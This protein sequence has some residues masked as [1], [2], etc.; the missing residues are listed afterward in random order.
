MSDIS[1]KEK[2]EL[3]K[4]RRE[5]A[6]QAQKYHKEQKK[7]AKKSSDATQVVR[8]PKVK[9][10]SGSKIEEA[11]NSGKTTKF[12][13]ISREEKFRRESEERIRNLEPQD[14]EDGYY[15]DEYSEKQRSER[16]AQVIRKQEHEVI[17]RNK[18]PVTQKQA[19]NRRILIGVAILIAVLVIGAILSL[20]VLFKTEKI[21]IDG[22]EYYYEDQIIAFSNVSLQQNIFLAAMG[23]TPKEIV[24]NL[25]YVEDA[26]ISFAIPDTVTIKI[27]NAMP[28]YYVKDGDKYLIIS[29]KGR[30]LDTE[31]EPPEDLTELV[32]NDFSNKE[33]GSYIEFE[34][35]AIP[36]ILETVAN[37]LKNNGLDN[38]TAFD[39][40]DPSSIKINYAGRIVINIGVAEDIEYKIKTAAAIITQKLDPNKTGQVYGTL[41]VS[42]CSK[43]KM[44]HFKPAETQ[45]ATEPASTAPAQGADG[46]AAN[47]GTT[48]DWSAGTN[49][50]GAGVYD[51]NGGAYDNGTQYDNGVQYD[52]GVG[53]ENYGGYDANAGGA[54]QGYD[55]NGGNNNVVN[56]GGNNGGNNGANNGGNNG[57]YNGGDVGG[58]GADGAAPY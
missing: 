33:V 21:D 36:D 26:K 4:Q 53:T 35:K 2:R 51:W 6:K 31:A 56:N 11:V 48:D 50:W 49:E 23:G 20:T 41:D 9:K 42:T 1:S 12:E 5:A 58:A 16:R 27:T 15:I 28:A 7:K 22:D 14:F 54:N 39:V 17:R 10:K 30:V 43:N 47:G 8:I 46:G 13:K 32:C 3:A 19:R 44:S 25:P 37:S 52:A 38:I 55:A 34:D 40:T 29:S 57:G 45:P 18:K 24:K